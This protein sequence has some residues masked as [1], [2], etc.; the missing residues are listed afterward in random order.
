MLNFIHIPRLK[1]VC[2]Y[3]YLH[4]ML[5][6]DEHEAGEIIALECYPGEKI[7][8]VFKSRGGGIFHDLPF[9]AYGLDTVVYADVGQAVFE[10]PLF[11]DEMFCFSPDRELVTTGFS[12]GILHFPQGNTLY[13]LMQTKLGPGLF[14][15]HK[16]C[17]RPVLPDWRKKRYG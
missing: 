8:T 7:T 10:D 6:G 14:P 2:K 9:I 17:T 11:D 16:I 1:V 5:P 3:D 12:R 13:H 15:S 4:D